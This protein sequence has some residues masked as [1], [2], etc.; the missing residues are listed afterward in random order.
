M[1]EKNE[2]AGRV[3]SVAYSP[4]LG[5]GI[6]LAYVQPHQAV[7]GTPIMIR[8]SS[9]ERVMAIVCKTPFYDPDNLRQKPEQ[10]VLRQE[11]MA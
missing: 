2:I 5:H 9:G 7:I 4:T 10:S 3:T 1:I 6:G 11:V 8:L